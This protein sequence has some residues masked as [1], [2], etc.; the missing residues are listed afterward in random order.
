MIAYGTNIKSDIPFLLNLSQDTEIR[1]EVELSSK[2]PDE[3]KNAI[4]CGSHFYRAHGRDVYL[5]SDKEFSA[6]RTGQPCCY[7]VKD[8]VCFYWIG[9]ER[10]I[11]YDL[12]SDIDV[13]LLSFW[14]I[15]L[16]L[17]LYMT[18]EDMYHFLHAG[19]VEVAGKPILFI[20]PSMGGKSTMIDYFIK[21]GHRLISDDKVA[22]FVDNGIF[23]T[24]GSHPYHRPYRKFEELGYRV[25]KFTKKFI[26]IHTFYE[27]ESVESDADIVI[28][29]IKGFAKLNALMSNYM[30]AFSYLK[31]G[32]LKYFSSMLRCTKIFH[33]QIPW[34]I[35]RLDEVYNLIC[36]HSKSL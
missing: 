16:F 26:P 25:E 19:A 7:E 32:Q 6:N 20:A 18:L 29:E 10:N 11:Y 23:K 33:I 34:N 5:Y 27:F 30:Y 8:I 15:H 4:R 17:P 1:Y 36:K 21:Q 22:T 24:V 2:V 28:E 9:G 35:E 12:D 13:N 14:F 31:P 3:L